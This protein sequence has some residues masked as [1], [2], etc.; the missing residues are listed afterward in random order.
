MIAVLQE[1]SNSG[2]DHPAE[3]DRKE[4]RRKALEA[5]QQFKEAK[6]L[7]NKLALGDLPESQLVDPTSSHVMEC[8]ECDN[9]R[10]K[11]SHSAIKL[12]L[13]R[14][15]TGVRLGALNCKTH[16]GDS[17]RTCKQLATVDTLPH[18]ERLVAT[19]EDTE[20]TALAVP[21]PPHCQLRTQSSSSAIAYLTSSATLP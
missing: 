7:A 21:I 1:Q 20:K 11:T 4:L 12:L 10:D 13:R 9:L 14:E 2:D 6:K 3:H 5:R 18:M 8:V 17:V 16:G 19:Q 15:V